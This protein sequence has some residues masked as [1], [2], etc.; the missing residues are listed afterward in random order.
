MVDDLRSTPAEAGPS[1]K[2]P[3]FP[4]TDYQAQ[5]TPD[6]PVAGPS[7]STQKRLANIAPHR[8]FPKT[9]YGSIEYPGPVSAPSAILQLTSQEEIN[10]CFNATANDNALLE[11]NYRADKT[12][13]PARGYRVPTQKLLVK[14]VKRRR[15]GGEGGV[16]TSEV[17]GPVSQTVRFRCE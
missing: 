9:A 17:V 16:F 8:H 11:I 12:G 13:G 7:R 15:K 10:T 14:V 3:D 5:F 1:T 4:A 2:A 6:Q